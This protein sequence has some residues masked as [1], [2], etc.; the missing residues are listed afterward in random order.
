VTIG[1]VTGMVSPDLRYWI[2]G[3]MVDGMVRARLYSHLRRRYPLT[4]DANTEIVIEGFPRSANTYA[5]VAFWIANGKD[6]PVAHHNH[7]GISVRI[8]VQRGIPVIVVVRDPLDAVASWLQYRPELSART[9]LRAY[10]RFY[11]IVAR[12]LDSVVVAPFET[13]V[14]DFASVIEAVNR[15]FGTSYLPYVPSPENEA[16]IRHEVEWW[17]YVGSGHTEIREHT[18]SRPSTER[19]L[20]KQTQLERIRNE[21]ELLARAESLFRH[22]GASGVLVSSRS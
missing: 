19:D 2:D 13:V 22:V 4:I 7:A 12:K 8:G 10:I 17:D 18:V 3:W 21:D 16:R 15:R 9:T 14:S 5:Y 6:I 1:K 11:E 20:L